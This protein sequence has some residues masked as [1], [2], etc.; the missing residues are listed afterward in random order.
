MAR[1]L[2]GGALGAAAAAAGMARHLIWYVS[3]QMDGTTRD[4]PRA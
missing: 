4:E 1:K 2:I 3:Y